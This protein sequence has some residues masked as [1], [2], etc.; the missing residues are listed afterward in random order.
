MLKAFEV[1]KDCK[2][3]SLADVVDDITGDYGWK[4][5]ADLPDGSS[6]NTHC[7]YC[8]GLLCTTK[9]HIIQ[10]DPMR[11]HFCHQFFAIE[12]RKM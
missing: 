4:K 8:R 12:L 3:V 7:P 10:A 11:C 9:E 1:P 2:K 6:I 5:I